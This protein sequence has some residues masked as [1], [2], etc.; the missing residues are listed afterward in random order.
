[1][2][3]REWLLIK[4]PKVESIPILDLSPKIYG[5]VDIRNYTGISEISISSNL[6]YQIHI[7]SEREE[8]INIMDRVS[9]IED[10][11]GD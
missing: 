4:P 2:L 5:I 11:T 10:E 1:M 8:Q 7:L 3:N 6:F 9:E